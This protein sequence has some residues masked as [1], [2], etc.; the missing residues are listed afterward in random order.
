MFISDDIEKQ[1][2]LGK[3]VSAVPMTV[4]LICGLFG[5]LESVLLILLFI[6][7]TSCLY[8]GGIFKEKITGTKA[9]FH[10]II[11]AVIC[12]SILIG[13]AAIRLIALIFNHV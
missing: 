5:I 3:D 12:N 1:E 6:I 8:Y 2:L 7:P 4:N 11:C 10:S 13:Y 9:I